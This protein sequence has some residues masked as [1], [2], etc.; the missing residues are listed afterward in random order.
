MI[1]QL[2]I[3]T[4]VERFSRS[5]VRGESVVSVNG[6]RDQPSHPDADVNS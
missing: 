4:N 1:K 6:C 5:Y 2:T 3:E